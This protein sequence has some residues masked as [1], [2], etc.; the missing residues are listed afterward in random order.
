MRCLAWRSC[1]RTGSTRWTGRGPG[2]WDQGS[3]GWT[4]GGPIL[5]AA[6]LLLLAVAVA[7]GCG[8]RGAAQEEGNR[9]RNLRLPVETVAA[10]AG[11]VSVS[12]DFTG[13]IV[14]ASEVRVA[15][16]SGG[17][18][19]AVLVDV[20]DRVAPGQLLVRLESETAAARLREADAALAVASANAR[21]LAELY[22]EGALA[23]Q[24]VEQAELEEERARVARDLAREAMEATRVV[25][26][27]DG[28][29]AARLVSQGDTVPPGAPVITLVDPTRLHV[30]GFLSE[31]Q[32]A[33]VAVG[34]QAQVLVAGQTV[35]GRVERVAPAPDPQTRAYAVKVT[36]EGGKGLRPGMTARVRIAL[37]AERGVVIPRAALVE[38]D[39]GVGVYVVEGGVARW[40]AVVPGLDDGRR[41][42]VL[43]GLA[44]GE[45]VVVTG[46]A[47][48]RDG[49]PVEARPV[50]ETQ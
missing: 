37:Q 24:A 34:G 45:S 20:G 16:K 47:Y 25:A 2:P 21:R 26:P 44:A 29:V 1:W 40:R 18:V 27:V 33:R 39:G 3:T 36:L 6:L 13:R 17:R 43:R 32:V 9:D 42:A 30:E 50:R 35:A 22:R 11:S 12:L 19:E 14:P 15:A 8:R 4:G 41:V 28:E 5:R 38:A 10:V 46:Q 23:R 31:S 7:G 49:S 48:V